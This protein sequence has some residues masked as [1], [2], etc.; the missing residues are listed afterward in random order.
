MKIKCLLCFC[1]IPILS[2]LVSCTA[3]EFVASCSL[4]RSDGTV[5]SIV[6]GPNV[7]DG[8]LVE[9]LLFYEKGGRMMS[10]CIEEEFDIAENEIKRVFP[11]AQG[12][13]PFFVLETGDTW[14]YVLYFGSNDRIFLRKMETCN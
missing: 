13:S 4:I 6:S 14:F 12:T 8:S 11:F 9:N 1:C 7:Y 5:A 10:V 3:K 2:A